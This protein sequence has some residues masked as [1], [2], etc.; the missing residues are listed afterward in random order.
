MRQFSAGFILRL[1]NDKASG[2]VAAKESSDHRRGTQLPMRVPQ[3]EADF[4]SMAL[5]YR[6]RINSRIFGFLVPG[7]PTIHNR[8][9]FG[10]LYFFLASRKEGAWARVKSTTSS[11]VTV[12]ISWCRLST[13]T[14]VTS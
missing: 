8:V 11:P 4:I 5:E 7:R 9:R 2:F 10:R 6:R 14:S 1:E 12:L 3:G 13:L